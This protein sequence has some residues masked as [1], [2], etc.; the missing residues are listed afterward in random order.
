MQAMIT[1]DF[2]QR[3][4]GRIAEVRAVLS[5]LSDAHKALSKIAK[6]QD[7]D[8]LRVYDRLGQIAED[9]VEKFPE[10]APDAELEKAY[11]IQEQINDLAGDLDEISLASYQIED[12]VG[13]LG[14]AIKEI[15]KSLKE[16]EVQLGKA[17][18]VGAK[19]G[20]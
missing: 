20:V 14:D 16:T 8:K 7:S 6:Q 10:E 18:R 9:V 12:L 11:V 3:T 15:Y 13:T 19:L 4:R 2:V 17:D 1:E 5:K